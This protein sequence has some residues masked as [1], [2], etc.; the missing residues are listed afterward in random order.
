MD[1]LN[2][3]IVTP[4]YEDVESARMLFRGLRECVG[5]VRIVAVDDG[6]VRHPVEGEA[7]ESSG[8]KG[9]V[10][11]LRRNLGHQGAI[12]VGLCHVYASM[13]DY[14]CVVVMDSDGEDKPESVRE[15][16]QGFAESEADVRVAE[17]NKRGESMDF[18][19]FYRAYKF[20]FRMLTGKTINFGNF[21]ALKPRAVSRLAAMNEIWLHLAASVIASR[22]RIAGCKIDRGA[23]YVGTSQMNFVGLVLHGF[24][25]VMVFAEQVLIRMGG[26]S[27][28]IATAS[29][30]VIIIAILLKLVDAA[31]PGWLSTVVGS[32]IVIFLLTGVLT[33][34]TLMITGLVRI[35]T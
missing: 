23:R 21:M 17:R 2:V 5:D 24:K 14:D 11:R 33:L 32:M 34:I 8:T 4:V 27:L 25:G 12:A 1:E 13:Q 35:S 19:Q 7:L 28:I 10:I 15:L 16:L 20:L 26:A 30:A 9:A 18:I 6:S 3:V 29:V 31:S 22:L